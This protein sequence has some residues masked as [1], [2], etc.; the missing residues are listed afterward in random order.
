M[1]NEDVFYL[2]IR[3]Q[4]SDERDLLNEPVSLLEGI[5]RLSDCLLPEHPDGL[6][7]NLFGKTQDGRLVYLETDVEW[8]KRDIMDAVVTADPWQPP[9]RRS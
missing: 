5:K 4:Q 8:H 2:S 1:S 7:F 9:R 3:Y 6:G